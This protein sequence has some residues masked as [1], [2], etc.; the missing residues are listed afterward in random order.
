[1]TRTADR[2]AGARI[3]AFMPMPNTASA[4]SR[5]TR[6]RGGFRF[7]KEPLEL[8]F[9]E[10]GNDRAERLESLLAIAGDRSLRVTLIQDGGPSIVLNDGE[11]F[12]D[13]GA[14]DVITADLAA[15]R[16]TSAQVS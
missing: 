13:K 14:L 3:C 11:G 6:H 1:M 12:P 7:G 16:N 4:S 10:L 9:D 8:T 15:A 5:W 2:Y